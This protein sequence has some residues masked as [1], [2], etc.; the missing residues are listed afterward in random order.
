MGSI[1]SDSEEERPR[2][3]PPVSEKPFMEVIEISSDSEEDVICQASPRKSVPSRQGRSN[4][5]RTAAAQQNVIE[6]TDS[7][8]SDFLDLPDMLPPLVKRPTEQGPAASKFIHPLSARKLLPLYADAS[9]DEDTDDGSILVLDNPRGSRKP[10]RSISPSK[11]GAPKASHPAAPTEPSRQAPIEDAIKNILRPPTRSQKQATVSE[12][13]PGNSVPKQPRLLKKAQMTEDQARRE[14]YATEL[15]AELNHDVFGDELPKETNLEWNK[16]LLTTAGR[17]CW[18]RSRDGAHT[19]K[20]E[21]AAKILD[22]NERIRNTMS[23]EMCH[24][25]CWI[26]DNNPQEGHGQLFKS[27]ANKVM[28]KRPDIQISTRHNYEISYPYEWKCEK[29]SKIYGRYSKSIRPDA[30]VC[31]A[32][33]IGKLVP[34]FAQRIPR[35]S[36]V[37]RMTIAGH[38]GSPRLTPGG[39]SR[40]R[41]V[42]QKISTRPSVYSLSSGSDGDMS[43]LAD[44]V[45]GVSIH[46]HA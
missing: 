32:C 16:R 46:G 6:L 14:R 3:P 39:S 35:T 21:L 13:P 11:S 43:G 9:D 33:K 1:I 15:F 42:T 23:H 8:P 30:C 10:I 28:R 25:A 20:I 34:L 5:R 12:P 29:C 45:Q 2:L 7:D 24:L 26:I 40:S 19:T 27:W 36:K 18:H 17:A 38:Q 22:C 31:G 41:V 4:L 44:A 37:S